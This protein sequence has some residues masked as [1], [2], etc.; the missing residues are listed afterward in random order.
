MNC[1]EAKKLVASTARDLCHRSLWDSIPIEDLPR[2][3]VA[4]I[5]AAYDVFM[6]MLRS[7]AS[8]PSP[9]SRSPVSPA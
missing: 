3:D 7:A 1:Q 4:R 2:D 8:S 9:S 6:T 5:S